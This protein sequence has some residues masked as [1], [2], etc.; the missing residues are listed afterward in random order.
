[1][2]VGTSDWL[3]LAGKTV[4]QPVNEIQRSRASFGVN[5]LKTLIFYAFED[6]S[7]PTLTR[8]STSKP[9]F[10]PSLPNLTGDARK[11]ETFRTGTTDFNF[12]YKREMFFYG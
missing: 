6:S 3:A 7:L 5:V 8:I 10:A 1:M 9:S 4:G 11:L 12:L 2:G